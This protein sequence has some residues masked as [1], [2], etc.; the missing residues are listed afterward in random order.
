MTIT[1]IDQSTID[2]SHNA[3]AEEDPG[4][5]GRGSDAGAGLPEPADKRPEPARL[6]SELCI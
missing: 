2:R 5:V 4:V 3:D 6:R 1:T